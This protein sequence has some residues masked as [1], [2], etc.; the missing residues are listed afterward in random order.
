[1]VNKSSILR[2]SEIRIQL[3][4]QSKISCK[5]VILKKE[6]SSSIKATTDKEK[7]SM[8]AILLKERFRKKTPKTPKAPKNNQFVN[9]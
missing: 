5:D 6:K 2:K 1:M 9:I 8:V 4:M 7:I 3:N